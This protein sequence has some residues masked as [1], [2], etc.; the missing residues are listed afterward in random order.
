MIFYDHTYYLNQGME[1]VF[2][3]FLHKEYLTKIF[4]EANTEIALHC[5]DD[6][7]RIKEG[8][9]MELIVGDES[10]ISSFT[11]EVVEIIPHQLIDLSINVNE[12][13]DKGHSTIQEDE[14]AILFL[15]KHLGLDMFFR[16]EFYQDFNS[17][18]VIES[19]EIKSPD[20]A[21]YAKGFWKILGWYYH[22]KHREIHQQIQEEIENPW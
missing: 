1:R 10:S 6:E 5:L 4:K 7:P 2:D 9:P 19:G 22:F 12:F 15:K 8:E 14:E 17:V 16:L 21:W 13:V 20:L 3:Y 11:V 18:R